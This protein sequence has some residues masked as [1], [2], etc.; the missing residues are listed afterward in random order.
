LYVI[1]DE[2]GVVE[3]FDGGGQGDA[4]LGRDVQAGREVEA[5]ASADTFARAL[6]QIFGGLAKAARGAGGV[7]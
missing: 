7:A 2:G 5:E 4:V 3:K 6:E 1:E